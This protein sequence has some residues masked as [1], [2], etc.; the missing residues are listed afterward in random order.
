LNDSAGRFIKTPV[1]ILNGRLKRLAIEPPVRLLVR[2]VLKCAPVSVS[3]RALWDISDR[4]A[5]LL[6][7][8]CAARQALRQKIREISVI[9]FGVAG[10]TGLLALEREARSVEKELGVSIK[11]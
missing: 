6:G 9:E 10:G 8:L 4:P 2:A 7:V 1:E 11:V 3:T 5:Y